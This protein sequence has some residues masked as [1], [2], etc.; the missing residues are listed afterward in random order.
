MNALQQTLSFD[1]SKRSVVRMNAVDGD[2]LRR[3]VCGLRQSLTPPPVCLIT[4][5]APVYGAQ[6]DRL[7]SAKQ[8]NAQGAKRII[9]A[10]HRL[11]PAAA[12]R[13]SQGRRGVGLKSS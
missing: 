5:T 7:C 13:M 1:I 4:Q 9:D 11:D 2:A 6:H 8:D 12:E 10:A 3:S